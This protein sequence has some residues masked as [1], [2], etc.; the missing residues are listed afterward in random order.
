VCKRHEEKYEENGKKGKALTW[1]KEGR[2]FLCVHERLGRILKPS[3]TVSGPGV[4]SS[5]LFP[6]PVCSV[7][8][9]AVL[10]HVPSPLVT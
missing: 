4:G 10:P 3:S 7:L 6:T 8:E 9:N 1:R 5:I 2:T